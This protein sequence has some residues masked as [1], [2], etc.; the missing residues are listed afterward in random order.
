MTSPHG[1]G[2]AFIDPHGNHAEALLNHIPKHRIDDVIYLNV[3]DSEYPIPFNTLAGVSLDDRPR[4]ADA[5]ITT[6]K[7]VWQ[8]LWGTGR[9]QDITYGTI[10]ALLMPIDPSLLVYG[11]C[12]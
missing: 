3:A 6:F 4:V 10:A 7:H 1:H 11:E 8:D 2:F 12:S 9:M 5:H